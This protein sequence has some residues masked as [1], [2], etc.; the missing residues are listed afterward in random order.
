MYLGI[1][2][3]KYGWICAQLK[4]EA[5]SLTLLGHINEVKKVDSQRIFIDI[6]IGLS[7]QFNTRTIDF[8]LRKLLSKKRK[9]SVFTPPIREA[10]EAPTYQLGNQINKSIS[11]KGIS[12]QAWNIGHKIKEVN[13]FLSQNHLY[14][15]KMSESH[16]ELCFE[17]LNNGPLNHS[18]KTLSGME[19]RIKIINK[20]INISSQEIRNFGK[21]CKS[22]KAKLDDIIDAIVLSLSAMRWELSGKRQITQEKEKDTFKLPFNIKY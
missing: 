16:P 13:Q 2:G 5:I 7:D 1:D 15:K 21:E 14:Q 20:Y 11:G 18:K 22:D 6:P 12:I 3:C 17:L 4:N 19:E 8:E 9:S 10:L